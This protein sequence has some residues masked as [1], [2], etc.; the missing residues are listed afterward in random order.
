LRPSLSGRQRDTGIDNTE[1]TVIAD[2]IISIR[3]GACID[4]QRIGRYGDRLFLQSR[5]I[6]S[7]PEAVGL[8]G[9]NIATFVFAGAWISISVFYQYVFYSL[10]V[11]TL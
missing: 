8:D 6:V 7:P 11:E 1:N 2:I 5:Q 4:V 9:G 3:D 10:V